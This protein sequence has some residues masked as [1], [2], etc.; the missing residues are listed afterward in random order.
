MSTQG[1]PQGAEGSEVQAWEPERFCKRLS[2]AE[3]GL[4]RGFLRCRPEKWFPGLGAFWTPAMHAFGCDVSVSDIRPSLSRPPM[5]GQSFIAT[6]GGEQ[7]LLSVDDGSSA[8]LIGELVP[9]AEEAAAR[10]VVEYMMR[11]LFYSLVSSWTGPEMASAAFVGAAGSAMPMGVASVRLSV[12]VNTTSAVLWF[13]LGQKMVDALDGLW[14]RQIQSSARGVQGP[15]QARIEVAQLGVPPQTLS[16]YLKPGTVIDLEIRASDMVTIRV[17]G[18]PWMPGRMVNVD[19]VFGCEVVPGA[20]S[21]SVVAEGTTR[22]SVELGSVALDAGQI[23][24]FGQAGAVLLS[25]TA[26]GEQVNLVINQ[27]IVGRARLCVYEGR[28]AIEVL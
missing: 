5:G 13:G 4:S 28:F 12:T 9:G 15:T 10:V 2:G 18:K 21:A 26:V 17:G 25:Q 11:R 23:A 20:V 8:A 14:R 22:L 3:V 6:V 27:E 16:E 1:I 24:E 19:G 7:M